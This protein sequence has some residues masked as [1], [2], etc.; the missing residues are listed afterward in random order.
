MSDKNYVDP[1]GYWVYRER[2]IRRMG[3][4]GREQAVIARATDECSDTEW[5]EICEA[6]KISPLIQP[7]WCYPIIL[8]LIGAS[9]DSVEVDSNNFGCGVDLE[10][11]M[12]FS[13]NFP[14]PDSIPFIIPSA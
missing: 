3:G 13:N 6:L 8:P 4:E 12:T 2:N 5:N 1:R 11:V 7:P 10:L 14:M 9:D